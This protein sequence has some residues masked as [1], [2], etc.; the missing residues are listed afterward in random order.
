MFSLEL[1]SYN[2]LPKEKCDKW[3]NVS[4][5]LIGKFTYNAG[6]GNTDRATETLE[7]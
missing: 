4:C 1:E 6:E 2:S 7:N 3:W 5:N